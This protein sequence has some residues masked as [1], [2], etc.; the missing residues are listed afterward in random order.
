LIFSIL[1]VISIMVKDKVNRPSRAKQPLHAL[2][3]ED[4]DDDTNLLLHG[5]QRSGAY[6]ITHQR[7]ETAKAL[8]AALDRKSWDV[9][10]CDF[11]MPR[12]SG[13]AALEIVKKRDP[14][15]PFIFV[16]GTLGEDVAVQAMKAGAHDYVMKNNLARLIP[17]MERG[18]GEANVRRQHRQA[19]HD[20]RT[21]E[22]KY[23][24]LFE[25]LGDAAFLIEMETGRIVDTNPQ[26][27]AL[28]GRSRAEILGMK[29]NQL[30]PPQRGHS[31][32]SVTAREQG[33]ETV[34]H[35]KSGTTVPVHVS[36]SQFELN[37]RQV[38]LALVH[39][40]TSSKRSE[41]KMEEQSNLLELAH[42]AI[43][44]RSLD[45]KIQYWNKGAEL[46][47]G[48][49]AEE[50]TGDDC[51]K[52][53]NED[54][55]GFEVAEKELLK[56]GSWSGEVRKQ[57]KA[58][59]TVVV[60]SRWT[61]VRD[62]EGSPSSV[63]VIDTDITEK[64]Q[65]ELHLLRDQRLELIGT[66]AGGI[67]H[68]LNNILQ[69]II[70]NLDLE[71]SARVFNE[72]SPKYLDDACQGAHRAAN[73]ARRLL[74]FSKG[75]APIK[76]P[77][78][79]AEILTQ[80]VLL[81]LSGSKLKPFF[82][83]RSNLYPI[84]GDPVQLTQVIENVVINACE[85]T[86]QKGRL[87]VRAENVDERNVIPT[88][89]PDGRYVRIEIED[90]GTGIDEKIR[91][92]IFEVCFTTKLG[93]SGLG[94]ATVKSIMHQHGGRI[95]IDSRIGRGTIV[96]LTLPA[97]EHRPE[98]LV[99]SVPSSLV[100]TTGR[101]L[102]VD[103]EEMILS[104]VTSMLNTLGY[105]SAVAQDGADGLN[106][107]VRAKANG[108]PFAAVLL[109]ATIPNAPGGEETLKSLLEADPKARVILCSGYADSDLFKEAEQLGFKAVLAKPFSMSEF[110]SV[111]NKV[112]SS[113]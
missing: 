41:T 14:D 86:P 45:G 18:L 57:T 24:H 6:E 29:E 90:M 80:S 2:I 32:D 92:R 1:S 65:M 108:N 93:G 106:Q 10:F 63:L 101:I 85:A 37:S 59:Q 27:E 48:W 107:Y 51:G 105:K 87:L 81:A 16:S 35:R 112:L 38:L 70:T 72:L 89:L 69:V 77:L 73:L 66:L 9:L 96:S 25:S 74:T 56:N 5:L 104:V 60:A 26:A 100:K 17:A 109:D 71:L 62:S 47:Y 31:R 61:L 91:D 102:V 53:A 103:D 76:Q 58:K 8:R 78:D 113:P 110:V 54:R 49:R 4:S 99:A 82:S 79:V 97:A 67:A 64:K 88:E 7:V 50:V 52:M 46:L 36:V 12:F 55:T 13:Q 11:T 28:L 83:F 15:L 68:D 84:V 3:V 20:M 22:Y 98:P 23:R 111:F 33:I 44:V 43:F 39:D 42:D 21:S 40:L 30:Y 95:T 34:I 75:G 94:L 19:E